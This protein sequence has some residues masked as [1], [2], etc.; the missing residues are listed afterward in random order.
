MKRLL[1]DKAGGIP[2]IFIGLVF[3][4][5]LIA[6]LIMEMGAAYDNYYDAETILQRS[7]NS[8]VE[9]N[10]LDAYRA[11]S[12]LRLDVSAAKADFYGYLDSDMPDKYTV[13]INSI[14]GSAT[15]LAL[16]VTGTVTFST[17][18]EQYGFDDLSFNF[19]VRST[20][21]RIEQQP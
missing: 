11:D 5:L 15:P 19:T 7:C 4:L 6:F 16:A 10:M 2:V 1:K 17:L 12:I 20:N 3:F 21:Y 14:T 8:A 18:F 13:R 9:K